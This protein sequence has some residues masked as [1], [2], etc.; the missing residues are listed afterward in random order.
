M[1]R[2]T[3]YL[4]AKQNLHLISRNMKEYHECE[5]DIPNNKL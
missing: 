5:S 4:F 1:G 3:N 2:T